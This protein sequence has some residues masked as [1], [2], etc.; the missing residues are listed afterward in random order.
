M[1]AIA[2]REVAAGNAP[3]AAER[4]RLETLGIAAPSIAAGRRAFCAAIRNGQF[5]EPA[6]RASALAVERTNVAAKLAIA[7]PKFL[8]RYEP[9]V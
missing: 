9:L 6:A 4:A 5:A 3:A 7:N 8:E 1:L 2:Q